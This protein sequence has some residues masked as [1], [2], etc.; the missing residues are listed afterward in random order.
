MDFTFE[1]G[2]AMCC[3]T[4]CALVIGK[5]RQIIELVDELEDVVEAVLCCRIFLR[6]ALSFTISV[7]HI[8]V[9]SACRGA[10]GEQALLIEEEV[11]VDA[12]ECLH[13]FER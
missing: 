4:K 6:L 3:E 8:L 11:F 12:A 9:V 5:C 10:G 2:L 13:G 1:P 7:F